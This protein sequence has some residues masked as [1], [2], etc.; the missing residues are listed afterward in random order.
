MSDSDNLACSP[1]ALLVFAMSGLVQ[2]VGSVSQYLVEAKKV[3]SPAA[4]LEAKKT[5]IKRI[6]AAVTA[7][8]PSLG[9][10]AEILGLVEKCGT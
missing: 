5:Q 3:L 6:C 2:H 8:R 9:E 10:A 7:A 4:F 1:C